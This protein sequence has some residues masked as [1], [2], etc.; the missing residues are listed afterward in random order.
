MEELGNGSKGNRKRKG[1]GSSLYMTMRTG[2]RTPAAL[3]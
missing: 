2:T 3:L 1:I